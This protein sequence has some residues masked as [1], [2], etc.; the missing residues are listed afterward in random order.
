M[1]KK[2][3]FACDLARHLKGETSH[4][5][6]LAGTISVSGGIALAAILATGAGQAS[7]WSFPLVPDALIVSSSTYTGT[8]ATVTVGQTL[9]GGG[10]A[11]N[12][13]TYPNVFDNAKVD[14]SFGV[15]SPI[16]LKQYFL[17][18]DNRSAFLINSLNVTERTVP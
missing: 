18:R 2:Q 11:T 12:D 10:T 1:L 15:T 13:G 16:I 8:A 14:G 7:E 6:L 17:S 9:P 5:S 3:S 4:R